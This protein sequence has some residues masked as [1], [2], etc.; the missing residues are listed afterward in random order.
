MKAIYHTLHLGAVLLTVNTLAQSS[1]T[2]QLIAPQSPAASIIG[3][4]PGAVE[5]PKTYAALEGAIFNNFVDQGSFS[6]PND[7]SLEFM[8]YW[9]A[10]DKGRKTIG[11]QEFL[12]PKAGWQTMRQS[13]ALSLAATQAFQL[14]DSL[15]SNG[16]GL[17]FRFMVVNGGKAQAEAVTNMLDRSLNV[18]SLT[19]RMNT[20]ADNLFA[21]PGEYTLSKSDADRIIAA[22]AADPQVGQLSIAAGFAPADLYNFSASFMDSVV[23]KSVT[24]D[25]MSDV[26]ERIVGLPDQVNTLAATREDPVGFRLQVAGACLVNYPTNEAEY[27][28]VP[29]MGFWLT[30]S[31]RFKDLRALEFLGVVRY[32]WY[33]ADYFKQFDPAFAAFDNNLDLGMRVAW[34]SGKFSLE[35]EVVHRYSRVVISSELDDATGL[36]TTQSKSETQLQYLFNLNYHISPTMALSYNYGKQLGQSFNLNVNG[37]LVNLLTLN[38]GFGAPRLEGREVV[39]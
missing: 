5:R 13:L 10:A 28:F 24:L 4:Q 22:W 37:D 38:V 19:T 21:G 2:G 12:A 6:V 25:R 29:K 15:R 36:R 32:L 23:T 18:A 34:K 35:G 14:N 7:F 11:V 39:R 3:L 30:P 17:G 20:V 1:I 31:Y 33:Q 8:P 26:V 9:A 27:A 16:L